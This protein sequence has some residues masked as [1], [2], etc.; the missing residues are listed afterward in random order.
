M[1]LI[2]GIPLL[3]TLSLT[4][5][6]SPIPFGKTKFP[7]ASLQD[8]IKRIK[9]DIKNG[10]SWVNS[11]KDKFVNPLTPALDDVAASLRKYTDNGFEG[12]KN[13]LPELFTR[14]NSVV[15]QARTNL[16]NLIGRAQT[17][18]DQKF[19]GLSMT[20]LSVLGDT[21][22]DSVQAFRNH[23]NQI[24]GVSPEDK[25][26]VTVPVYGNVSISGATVNVAGNIISPNTSKVVY[27]T[28]E[29]GELINVGW[30]NAQVRGK[31]YEDISGG[32]VSVDAG[33]DAYKLTT[34]SVTSLNLQNLGLIPNMHI[35]VNGEPKTI[36]SIN[37]A[38]DFLTVATPFRNSAQAV[39]LSKEIG[40]VV[41]KQFPSTLV[42][43]KDLTLNVRSEFIANS[44]CLD[45]YISGIGVDFT[46]LFNP[47]DKVL[48]D[49]KEFY[50][51]SVEQNRI[52]V[53]TELR[54][55][56]K[57]PLKKI[58]SEST[59]IRINEGVNVDDILS[60]F[61]ALDQLTG[62]MGG[63]L[64]SDLSTKYYSRTGEV[65]TVQATKPTDVTKSLQQTVLI[66]NVNKLL[67]D[68]VE[69]LQDDAIRSFTDSQLAVYLEEK[70]NLV[71][72]TIKQVNTIIED[73]L[74]AFNAVKGL[75]NG[76]LK[77]FNISCSKKKSSNGNTTSDDYLNLILAP[78]PKTQGCSATESDFIGTLDDIDREFRTP[79][80]PDREF[81]P[82]Q[83]EEGNGQFDGDDQY[84]GF[85]DEP[86]N[87]TEGNDGDVIIETG[88]VEPEK[89]EDPCAK[90]C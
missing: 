26:F 60:T 11:L 16:M 39:E 75:L 23:T 47:N 67:R 17:A 70:T 12:F 52:Q 49:E 33:T 54:L 35:R 8:L 81:V 10:K 56:T 27:P 77:L 15:A 1:C 89:P 73:D 51:L 76:L 38:G 66:N 90:P 44:L 59:F 68:L 36:V 18:A 87:A 72:D 61:D 25:S 28:V 3:Q 86:E 40:I 37:T 82:Y 55:L 4:F 83:D 5:T 88:P 2:G 7:P 29:I 63:N 46:G 57:K 22:H 64:T 53:D 85:I 42:A 24:S 21:L 30:M 48:Y 50:I 74:A 58:Q 19:L 31:L 6:N 65:R 79:D 71:N 32:T 69:D 43:Q 13:T 20:E 9:E 62:D 78:D 84:P 34:D 80:I 45:N 41:D 14:N